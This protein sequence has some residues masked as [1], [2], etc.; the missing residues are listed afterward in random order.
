MPEVNNRFFFW[1]K[2]RKFFTVWNNENLCWVIRELAQFFNC[3]NISPGS[4][5]LWDIFWMVTPHCFIRSVSSNRIW[6][7]K[8]LQNN[9]G[10]MNDSHPPINPVCSRIG[11]SPWD[12]VT[13]GTWI[14]LSS[15]SNLI[16][17]SNITCCNFLPDGRLT[18]SILKIVKSTIVSNSSFPTAFR[19]PVN[20]T[21]INF[22][23]YLFDVIC[24]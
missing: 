15:P 9:F 18:K 16:V 1:C 8:R 13:L 10:E 5:L 2:R 6:Y 24:C 19:I 14:S 7:G 4:T 3:L 11:K 20:W 12:T 23:E 22:K 21:V 17:T